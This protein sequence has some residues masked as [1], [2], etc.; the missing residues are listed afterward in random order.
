MITDILEACAL[1]ILASVRL[2][3]ISNIRDV[4]VLLYTIY[5]FTCHFYCLISE[6][7][8]VAE[9]VCELLSSLVIIFLP[10]PPS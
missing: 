1:V 6:T 7:H 3:S 8:Y 10:Q 4:H 9:S 5:L 2:T